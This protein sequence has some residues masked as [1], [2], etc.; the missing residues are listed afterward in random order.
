M[1]VLGIRISYKW[2]LHSVFYL[3]YRLHRCFKQDIIFFSYHYGTAHMESN[4][5][6]SN[7]DQEDPATRKMAY[8]IYVLYL[9]TIVLPILPIIGV[10]FGY[11]FENDAK[12]YLKSHYHY[13][14]RSFWIGIL[15]S[16]IAG[17]SR[18]V[19]VGIVLIPLCLI[20]WLIRAAKGLKSLMR[21]QPISNPE[22]WF[23]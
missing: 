7:T 13:I 20:W 16:L 9:A 10:I 1:V 6:I 11:I 19:V 23:F 3:N 8:T 21:N 5:P 2:F 15:Y 4:T 14:I 18:I 12:S 22:T 17:V